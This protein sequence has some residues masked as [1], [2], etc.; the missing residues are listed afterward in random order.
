MDDEDEA[1]RFCRRLIWPMGVLTVIAIPLWL[2]TAVIWILAIDFT[3][4]GNPLPWEGPVPLLVGFCFIPW[5]A[6][7]LGWGGGFLRQPRMMASEVAILG[8]WLLAAAPLW[9][10]M[11]QAH[12][13]P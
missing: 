12:A 6:F 11:R 2:L 1:E 4:A 13:V 9:L 7:F 10:L 8:I 3:A 5:V